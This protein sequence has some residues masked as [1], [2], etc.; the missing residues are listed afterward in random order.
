MSTIL[1]EGENLKAH[2]AGSAK[3]REVV[4]FK[5]LL[6]RY[7]LNIIVNVSFG[8]NVDTIGYPDHEFT[9][10][11]KIVNGPGL[12][13]SARLVFAFLCPSVLELFRTH[14]I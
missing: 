4:P 11:E 5:E 9:H 14:A 6:D 7:S 1:L 2:L 13:N 3:R 10:I 12:L 8:I